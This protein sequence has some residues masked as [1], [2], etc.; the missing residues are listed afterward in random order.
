MTV[1][2]HFIFILL[3]IT[4]AGCGINPGEVGPTST[5]PEI[6]IVEPSQPSSIPTVSPTL[7]QTP[8]SILQPSHPLSTQQIILERAFVVINAL[9]EKD[10]GRLVELVH[11]QMGLR[12][13]P[14]ATVK[15]SD[16]VFQAAQV[17][18]LMTDPTVYLWGHFDG[19]GEPINLTFADYY[20]KFV[21]D[22]DFTNAPQI[23]LNHRLGMGN[24]I[25]NISEYYQEAMVVEFYFPGFDPQYEGMDWRSLRMVFLQSNGS[26]YLAGLVHDQW[27]I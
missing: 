18:G 6:I 9:K 23:A 20:A 7:T 11:P 8:S 19:S 2:L 14:Y 10:M 16:Q 27:T 15:D 26:W 24:S 22:E 13:S 21:Y 4:L 5:P 1:K 3:A 25:D 12:F 17:A